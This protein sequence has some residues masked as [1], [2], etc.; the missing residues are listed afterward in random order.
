MQNL[1]VESQK[2]IIA[3]QRCSIDNQK[4]AIAVQSLWLS[5]ALLVLNG[6]SLIC[7]NALLALNWRISMLQSTNKAYHLV[8]ILFDKS[9]YVKVCSWQITF[10]F[11]PS[12]FPD[13][14]LTKKQETHI[15]GLPWFN[16]RVTRNPGT[17]KAIKLLQSGENIKSNPDQY[18]HAH[19]VFYTHMVSLYY[20]HIAS[21]EPEEHY[22]SSKMFRWEPEGRYCCTKSMAKSAFLVLDLQ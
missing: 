16:I 20:L 14:S 12:K 7:N 13:V 6:T 22:C 8:D 18:R 19:I 9:R 5:S 4:G 11:V 21:W 2:G 17:Y 10:S 3:I 1:S 15:S